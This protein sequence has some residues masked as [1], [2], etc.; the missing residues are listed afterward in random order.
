MNDQLTRKREDAGRL[1]VLIVDDSELFRTGL[2]TLLGGEGFDLADSSSGEAA[3]RRVPTFR[4]HVV[5]MDVC[6]PGM[7][8]VQ[9]TRLVL[10]AVPGT[11]VVMFT[12]AG[13]GDGMIEAVRAGA[14]GYL[15]KDGEVGEI[16]KGIRAAAAG[17]A[18]IAPQVAGALLANVRDNPLAAVEA[19]PP[20]EAQRLSA[21]E[22]QVLTLVAT[23]CDNVDIA[24]QLYLSPST[25][26]HH[27][28][29]TLAK[30]GVENRVQ[31]AGYAIRHGLVD[32]PVAP[33]A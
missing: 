30:L 21:R 17:H 10:E 24:Q 28:S 5:L 18:V 8:G 25:V 12:G 6:M 4:P 20:A 33:A 14:S 31:A 11:S 23:G 22:R 3:V 16:V 27:V 29:R 7:S 19:M 26:K 32:E 13:D 9:A 15:L 1:R 2:R